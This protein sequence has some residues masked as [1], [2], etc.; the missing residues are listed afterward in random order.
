MKRLCTSLLLLAGVIGFFG[1]ALADDPIPESVW[2][3]N[4]TGTWK[5]ATRWLNGQVPQA[6]CIVRAP[7]GATIVATDADAS[8]LTIVKEIASDSLSTCCLEI[9]NAEELTMSA[10]CYIK[11][12]K[13]GAGELKINHNANIQHLI[14]A[15][16]VQEGNVTMVDNVQGVSTTS[17]LAF[18]PINVASGCEVKMAPSRDTKITGG[19]T[20]AGTISCTAA[21]TLYLVGSGSP[22]PAVRRQNAA[23][24]SGNISTLKLNIQSNAGQKITNGAVMTAR[25]SVDVSNAYFGFADVPKTEFAFRVSGTEVEY[26]GSAASFS[27]KVYWVNGAH[28]AIYNAGPTGGATWNFNTIHADNYMTV[29]ELTGDNAAT[30]IFNGTLPY[31]GRAYAMYVKKTGSGTWRIGNISYG[32]HGVYDIRKGTLEYTQLAE[33]GGNSSLGTATICHSEYDGTKD[34]TK[35]VD[36]SLVIGDGTAAVAA[37]TATLKYVGADAKTIAERPVVIKGTGRFASDNAALDW[38]GFKSFGAGENNLILGGAASGNIARSVTDGTGTLSLT[39]DG[40]GSW[41]VYNPGTS[42]DLAVKAGRLDVKVNRQ[43]RWFKLV[44]KKVQGSQTPYISHIGFFNQDGEEQ[45]LGMVHNTAANGNP[46]L[47]QPGQC[48]AGADTTVETDRPLTMITQPIVYNVNS[49]FGHYPRCT[50]VEADS[51]TWAEL[52]FRLPDDADPIVKYDMAPGWWG[53]GAPFSAT[54]ISWAFYGSI[55]GANW[56]KLHEKSDYTANAG[57]IYW[58]SDLS[59]AASSTVGDPDI[60]VNPDG[61][62]VAAYKDGV[63]VPTI[64]SVS[65]ASGATLASDDTILSVNKLNYNATEGAGTIQGF[66][67]A[68]S[69]VLNLASSFAGGELSIPYTFTDCTGTD[70]LAG[71]SVSVGEVARPGWKLEKTASG[72]KVSKPGLHILFK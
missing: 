3:V 19:L 22:T 18:G 57:Y 26:L 49:R 71:W 2:L 7:S 15:F 31:E 44:V 8:Y 72:L 67:L 11:V 69:G 45:G 32:N 52:V 56:D 24:F 54:I 29:L 65:V 16:D 66:S 21:K 62:A 25:S 41:T 13:K 38:T 23:E 34:D 33:K 61:F 63:V 43:Y 58:M 40:A 5:D 12:R 20:G 60:N 1:S 46:L 17:A 37:D 55:D 28:T 51:T 59:K 9:D 10:R 50:M 53:S 4:G 68:S 6:G 36:Y 42:G 47:L 70:N 39:K 64:R 30:S 48:C 27:S 14:Y 35:A